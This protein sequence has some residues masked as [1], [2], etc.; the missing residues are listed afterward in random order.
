M[1]ITY[2]ILLALALASCNGWLD[3][4]PL[5]QVGEDKMFADERGFQES[6]AGSYSQLASTAAYGLELTA[7]FPDEIA[8]YWNKRSEFHD[9]NYADAAVVKRLSA[10][11][12]KMYEIIA[13]LNLLL[14]HAKK[15]DEKS[16]PR[17]NLIVGE[18]K[19]LRAYLHLD[20]L[21][22]FGPVLPDGLDSPSIPYRDEFSNNIIRRMPAREVLA[23]IE[24]DLTDARRLLQDDPVKRFGRENGIL[25]DDT[26]EAKAYAYA[27][28]GIRM[29]Y[30]AATATLARLHLLA[31]NKTAALERAR[32]V[33]AATTIFQPGNAKSNAQDYMYQPELV[34]AIHDA[35]I[36]DK[37]G[38]ASYFGIGYPLDA[39]FRS[40][41]YAAGHG[42]PDDA[43]LNHWWG[44]TG[45]TPAIDYL[46]K[47]IRVMDGT[48]DV[49]KWKPVISMIRLTELYY[50]A[51]EA[52]LDTDLAEARRL[53]QTV[54]DA[55]NLSTSPLPA[56]LS[57]EALLEQIVLEQ[58]KE[59][60]GEGKLFYTYKRLA[61]PII[62]RQS[63]IPF[64]RAIFELPVPTEEIEYGNN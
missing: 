16:L 43:R 51:A 18:A 46:S 61:R 45:T 14:E 13:N 62:I 25:V 22:L 8:R 7:G 37:L 21:R 31:G 24:T 57:R 52:L 6:L 28:R 11:W 55:R 19:G 20:L 26:R 23:R 17:Y 32:E 30:Y 27:Y 53:L 1:K 33:I 5:G 60:W 35:K 64:S 40:Y 58:L 38:S 12:N 49:T 9:F 54:R 48:T 34:W 47:Y 36:G 50:I 29:N 42:I 56:T 44:R 2:Y 59:F 4:T 10:T 39:A 3:V 63:T 15:Y 41:V